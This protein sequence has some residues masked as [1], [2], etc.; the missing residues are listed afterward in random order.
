MKRYI[1]MLLALFMV[2]GLCAC[3]QKA[4]A[5]A[6]QEQYDLG[7]R[8]L[9]EGNYEEAIIAFTAAIEIEPKQAAAYLGMAEVYIAQNDFDAARAILEQ[10]YEATGDESLRERLEELDSGT[11]SDYRGRTRKE[12]GYDGGGNLVWYRIYEYP[13]DKAYEVTSYDAE[14]NQTGRAY[15]ARADGHQIATVTMSADTGVVTQ[16]LQEFD[17]N[18]NCVKNTYYTAAGELEYYSIYTYDAA[19]NQT[20]SESFNPD[21]SYRG[22]YINEYDAA[23]HRIKSQSVLSDGTL[24]GYNEWSYDNQ[25]RQVENRVY[26]KDGTLSSYSV[27]EFDGDKRAASYNYNGDGT[28]VLKT[29]YVYDE[30]GQ[31]IG[32]EVYDGAGDLIRSTVKE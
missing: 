9:S 30:K 8:Y 4:A 10:G 19:G 24:G 27:A 5:S 16:S 15:C 17:A 28:L 32:E 20:R 23:G 6:W 25:G 7:I 21:G 2:V 22:G 29:V 3:G 12:S 13:E 18:G 11:F 31:Q 14:G 1:S 26:D